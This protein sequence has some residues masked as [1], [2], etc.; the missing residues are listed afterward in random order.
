[1]QPHGHNRLRGSAWCLLRLRY[2]RLL[3]A[4]FTL[5]RGRLSCG[6]LNR[7]LKETWTGLRAPHTTFELL[8]AVRASEGRKVLQIAHGI[9]V[10]SAGTDFCGAK[11]N[12][13]LD[14]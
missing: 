14:L 7:S 9:F 10:E 8:Q 3:L 4:A 13:L 11:L 1:M 6:G 5:G 12:L 2:W